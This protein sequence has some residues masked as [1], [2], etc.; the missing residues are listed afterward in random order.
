[1]EAQQPILVGSTVG[2]NS[3]VAAVHAPG[4]PLE[5]WVCLNKEE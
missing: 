5:W 4:R 2:S 1:V 3:G